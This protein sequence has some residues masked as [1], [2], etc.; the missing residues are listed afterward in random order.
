MIHNEGNEQCLPAEKGV[1]KCSLCGNTFTKGQKTSCERCPLNYGGCNFE[2][3]PNCGYD[4]P[5][6]SHLWTIMVKT[7]NKFKKGRRNDAKL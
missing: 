3:C 2:K 1:I 6:G 4:A 7:I 5:Q